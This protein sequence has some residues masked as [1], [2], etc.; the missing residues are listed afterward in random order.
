MPD[1]ST[2]TVLVGRGVDRRRRDRARRLVARVDIDDGLRGAQVMAL[3]RGIESGL[4]HGSQDVY[5]VDIVPIGGPQA[6]QP[7]FAVRQILIARVFSELCFKGGDDSSGVCFGTAVAAWHEDH[8]EV[9]LAARRNRVGVQ[10]PVVAQVI[11]DDGS[12]FSPCHGQ[13][14]GIRERRPA[15]VFCYRQ[16]VVPPF[17]ELA[18]DGR[19]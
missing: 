13:D 8:A 9:S 3:V 17:A 16:D 10:R 12:A 14:L 19:G 11:G 1:E 2:R 5:R 15:R 18:R 7:A 6:L 4:K